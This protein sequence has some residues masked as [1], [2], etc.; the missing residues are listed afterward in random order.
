MFIVVSTKIV[1]DNALNSVVKTTP[2]WRRQSF[3]ARK[4]LNKKY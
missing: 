1:R 3:Q 2:R 4:K